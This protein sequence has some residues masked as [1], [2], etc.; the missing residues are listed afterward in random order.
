MLRAFF[1]YKK[2]KNMEKTI[3]YH[4]QDK[5]IQYESWSTKLINVCLEKN[6]YMY[7]LMSIHK[8]KTLGT[9]F[10]LV[11]HGKIGNKQTNEFYPYFN[12]D[13][14][15][16]KF[17]EIYEEKTGCSWLSGNSNGKERGKYRQCPVTTIIHNNAEVKD[18]LSLM[19]SECQQVMTYTGS[20]EKASEILWKIKN[21]LR[22]DRLFRQNEI[23][24]KDLIKQYYEIIPPAKSIVEINSNNID[25]FIEQLKSIM[26]NKNTYQI[27]F[28][29]QNIVESLPYEFTIL[30]PTEVEYILISDYARPCS[31][32]IEQIIKLTSVASVASVASAEA[33]EASHSQKILL[34]HGTRRSNI[35]SIM[36]NGFIIPDKSSLMFGKGVYFADHVIKSLG[37][38]QN[39][40]FICQI[41]IS[42]L[43]K[44]ITADH[45]FHN[46]IN[47]KTD[48]VKGV[49]QHHPVFTTI[50]D[51]Q[52]IIPSGIY[53]TEK[54]VGLLNYN[55]YIVYNPSLIEIKYVV[56]FN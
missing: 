32:K 49:G 7:Y 17:N 37:Y 53:T 41:T 18:F 14:A 22:K 9:F 19:L 16:K 29:Q 51:T 4:L 40:L 23:D 56:K 12:C 35:L 11:D 44:R 55:E 25:T 39:Y 48:V 1:L 45:D 8:H 42:N 13:L 38:S 10:L 3:P 28:T 34:W 47:T 26:I 54:N 43:I 6:S 52:T 15:I 30:S 24:L 31:R 50:D 5:I 46:Q 20:L 27:Y 36:L 21:F 33:I 2:K